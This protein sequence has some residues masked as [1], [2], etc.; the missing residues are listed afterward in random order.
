MLPSLHPIIED[1][2]EGGAIAWGGG[3][4]LWPACGHTVDDLHF[5]VSQIW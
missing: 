2:V 5:N 3:G 4:P 1:G